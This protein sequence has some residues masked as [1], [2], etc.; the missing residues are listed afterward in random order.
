MSEKQ[1]EPLSYPEAAKRLLL[2]EPMDDNE[3][4]LWSARSERR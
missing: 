3:T 2:N 4:T 1:A